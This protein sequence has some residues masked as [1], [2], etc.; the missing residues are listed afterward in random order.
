MDET[1]RITIETA[2]AIPMGIAQEEKQIDPVTLIQV[3]QQ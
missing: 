3:R 1:F 2:K